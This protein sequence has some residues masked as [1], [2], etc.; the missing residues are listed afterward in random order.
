MSQPVLHPATA[1]QFQAFVAQPSHAVTLVGPTGSG[2]HTVATALVEAILD[3]ETGSFASYAY[4]RTVTPV[5]AKA[6][7]IEPIRELEH[8]LSLKVPGVAGFNRAVIIEDAHKLTTE[9][10]N[11]LLKTLEEPPEGTLIVLTAS[12]AQ[13]LLPTIRS[14][15][16]TITIKT[17]NLDSIQDYF[18]ARGHKSQAVAQTYAL[19]G[20]LMGLMTALLE[21][22][23]HPLKAATETA[24][25]LLGATTYD[26]LLLVDQLSKQKDLAQNVLFIIG[27]MA[28]VSLRSAT[29][30]SAKKWQS[31]LES[32]YAATELLAQSAQPKLVLTNLMLTL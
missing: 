3:L 8:F 14:R 21:D 15:T 11:A 2:K 31:I 19:S 26:R 28:H 27:Q 7:G 13:S 5:D 10:Q 32:S 29:G 23:D 1:R 22:A 17:P 9:A 16:Q 24:R 30:P 20:G 4:G 25:Q 6:I 18:V 12:H